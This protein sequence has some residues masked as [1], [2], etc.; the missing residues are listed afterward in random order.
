LFGCCCYRLFYVHATANISNLKEMQ[1]DHS[2]NC[3]L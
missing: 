1:L 2:T 3:R